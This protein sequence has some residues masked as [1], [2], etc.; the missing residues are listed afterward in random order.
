[1]IKRKQTTEKMELVALIT[2][3]IIY[4]YG[5]VLS[6]HDE[7]PGYLHFCFGANFNF[8]FW[9]LRKPWMVYNIL[10]PSK[11]DTTADNQHI[12]NASI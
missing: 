10:L 4:K 2:K 9:R 3:H 6:H 7:K 11:H 1:M 8:N 5:K 12:N